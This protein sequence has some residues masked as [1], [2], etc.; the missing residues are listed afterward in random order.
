MASFSKKYKGKLLL[1]PMAGVTNKAFRTIC[2]R[3][4]AA[5]TYTEMISAKGLEYNNKNTWDLVEPAPEEEKIA[6]Q[7]FGHE[8]DVMARQA[9]AIQ[10]HLGKRLALIDVNM[11]CPVK[12]VV[13]KGE[14]CALMKTPQL[15][16]EIIALIAK[17]VDVCVT[18]KI[19]SGWSL[20]AVNAV[21][22]DAAVAADTEID[23]AAAAAGASNAS[24]SGNATNACEFAYA[25][26]EA[27][28]A[29]IAVHGRYA[30]QMYRG[31]ADWQIIAN[32]KEA[33]EIPVIASGDIFS[34]SDA[35]ECIN[36]YGADAVM[37]ARGARINPW[38]FENKVPT[39]QERKSC[40]LE[41]LHL[42]VEFYGAK[43]L[44]PLRSQLAFYVH[45]L[46]GAAHFR[47][48]LARCTTASDFEEL[49]CD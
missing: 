45:G 42:Y 25:L 28:A 5:L 43:Y 21:S 19:R 37:V 17:S 3:R 15:A 48:A 36:K 30:K 2:L 22:V 49:I 20:E 6:V 18:A 8:P 23:A 32:V 13:S 7:L 31:K 38:I 9:H 10:S 41:H 24:S 12:K 33:L 11:G 26:Q 14:G 39:I 27:G 46:S 29:A 1:A 40:M 47:S 34:Y 44:A 16:A 35:Q 4:G